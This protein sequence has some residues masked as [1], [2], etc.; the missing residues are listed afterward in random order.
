VFVDAEFR[1]QK[2]AQDVL[3]QFDADYLSA[4]AQNVDVVML[5]ALVG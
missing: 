2:R 5:N 4:H 1:I 3:C